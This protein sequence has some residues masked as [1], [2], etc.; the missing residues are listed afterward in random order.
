MKICI[1]IFMQHVQQFHSIHAEFCKQTIY[2]QMYDNWTV[3]TTTRISLHIYWKC[4][5]AYIRHII[6]C[7]HT[8]TTAQFKWCVLSFFLKIYTHCVPKCVS[9]LFVG[10]SFALVSLALNLFETSYKT[11]FRNKIVQNGIAEMRQRER[12]KIIKNRMKN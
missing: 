9:F 4:I 8:H 12:T 3:S 2:P 6:P 10:I 7:A 5:Y 11:V 1:S